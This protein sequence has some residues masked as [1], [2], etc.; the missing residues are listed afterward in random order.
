[1]PYRYDTMSPLQPR[2]DFLLLKTSFFLLIPTWVAWYTHQYDIATA[3]GCIFLTSIANHGTNIQAFRTIDIGFIHLC[4]IYYAC[5]GVY[6]LISYQWVF[7]VPFVMEILSGIVY[8]T[9]TRNVQCYKHAMVHLFG[10]IG[11]SLFV[12]ARVCSRPMVC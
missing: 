5:E 8:W 7:V 2:Q 11:I 1:M 4:G 6:R 10:S 12:G 9:L 3:T